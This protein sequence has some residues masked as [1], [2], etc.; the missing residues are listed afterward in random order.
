M[1]FV[2]LKYDSDG[3]P[4]WFSYNE[5]SPL[6]DAVVF[7]IYGAA[8]TNQDLTGKQLVEA[9]TWD[10]L[11]Y[12]DTI[13]NSDFYHTG[14]VS[15]KGKFYGCETR[16]HHEQARYVHKT[17][18]RE[19]EKRGWI[20]IT[21]NQDLKKGLTVMIYDIAPTI[22]QIKWFKS[23]Y[24]EENREDV[25]QRLDLYMRIFKKENDGRSF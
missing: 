11:D 21:K 7:S 5:L 19:L 3:I 18:D 8:K 1:K 22:D 16:H 12:T 9:K 23:N 25:L 2:K 4:L 13:F 24:C 15:P 6:D 17:T 14:W 10:E 20:K